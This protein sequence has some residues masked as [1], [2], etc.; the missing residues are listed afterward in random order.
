MYRRRIWCARIISVD[1]YT[2]KK[3]RNTNSTLK[4]KINLRYIIL[5]RMLQLVTHTL[6]TLALLIVLY[7]DQPNSHQFPS[8]FKGEGFLV[9]QASIWAVGQLIN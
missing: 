2:T 3:D 7:I 9:G 4:K 1:N 8:P 5:L 6:V